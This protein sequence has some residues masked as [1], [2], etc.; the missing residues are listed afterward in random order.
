MATDS[1]AGWRSVFEG[2]SEQDVNFCE[3]CGAL[4]VATSDTDVIK[5]RLCKNVIAIDKFN[6][7]PVI[8]RSRKKMI[9]QEDE[10]PDSNKGSGAT[11]KEPCPECGHP[12]LHFHTA[13]L[14][15][16]DEGQTIFYECQNCGYK[17]SVNS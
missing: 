7:K 13:Q 9:E 8:M 5:C 15:S 16:A 17:F 3:H 2:D 14:R 1:C 11:V 6:A 10:K 12:E 4:L